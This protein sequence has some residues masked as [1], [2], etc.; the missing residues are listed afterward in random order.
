[1]LTFDPPY[2][3]VGE[4]DEWRDETLETF[5]ASCYAYLA[6]EMSFPFSAKVSGLEDGS[7]R[8]IELS[9]DYEGGIKVGIAYAE[10]D[11]EDILFVLLTQV[12]PLDGDER[13]LKAVENWRYWVSSCDFP[14][15]ST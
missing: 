14:L 10:D 4:W 2:G 1:M 15:W 6:G 3:W 8:V 12:E 9:E 11:S 13:T 7:F 5:R